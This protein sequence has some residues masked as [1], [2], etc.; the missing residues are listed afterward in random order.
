MIL[1]NKLANIL[2]EKNIQWKDLCEAGLSINTTTKFSQNR[3]MNTDNINKVCEYL[4]V[5]PSDIMEWI[6]DAEYEASQKQL[7][8]QMQAREKQK[9]EA[10]IAELQQKL[11]KL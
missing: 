1:Y 8:A 9:L 2:E 6:P 10:Q 11:N 7:E 3:T 4:Q 5:Q